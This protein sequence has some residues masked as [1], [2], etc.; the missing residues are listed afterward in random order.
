MALR[1][2]ASG[3]DEDVEMT[4]QAENPH[5]SGSTNQQQLPGTTAVNDTDMG[6]DMHS[7][8]GQ[9]TTPTTNPYML[10]DDYLDNDSQS[11]RADSPWVPMP[12]EVENDDASDTEDDEL[13][14]VDPQ[15]MERLA[16]LYE[17]EWLEDAQTL[18]K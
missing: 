12:V 5:I 6:Y 18:H 13:D 1:V 15:I 7:M 14:L 10:D 11:D 8:D 3:L 9:V 4:K 17:D 16:E 2:D